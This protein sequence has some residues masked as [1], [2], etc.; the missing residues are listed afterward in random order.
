MTAEADRP[1][2]NHAAVTA[3]ATV[4][5]QDARRGRS[6]L[7]RLAALCSPARQPGDLAPIFYLTQ[8]P[9]LTA[10]AEHMAETVGAGRLFPRP[11]FAIHTS[12]TLSARRLHPI[13]RIA[14]PL[15]RER[16]GIGKHGSSL[17]H[18]RSSA[19]LLLCHTR[20]RDPKGHA[21]DTARPRP[22]SQAAPQEAL[23]PDAV[24]QG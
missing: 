20:L 1:R 24:L 5:H 3:H 13:P 18:A 14:L 15:P 6:G 2:P 11:F 10:T 12:L 19:H 7:R 23:H 16:R 9:S 22:R 8:S 17:P 21:E 4:R